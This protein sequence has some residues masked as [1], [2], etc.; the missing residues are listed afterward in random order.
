[1]ERLLRGLAIVAMLTGVSACKGH[2]AH[3]VGGVPTTPS[4]NQLYPY[5]AELCA[6]SQFRK[7]PDTGIEIEGGGFG[8]HAVMFLNGV[9]LQK[10]AH[11]PVLK[12]CDPG[13]DP[14][15][16][17]VGISVN[18]HY[19]NANWIATQGRSFFFHGLLRKGEGLTRATYDATVREAAR[20]GVLDGVT[21]RDVYLKARPPGLDE[22]TYKYQISLGT[23]YAL[24]YARDR[25]CAKVPLTRAGMSDA[26]TYLNR[27]NAPY[28][29]GQQIFKW[30]VVRNNCSHLYHNVLSAAG[31]WPVWP[32]NRPL[33]V[34]AFS[35]PTPKNEFVNLVRWTNEGAIDDVEA[36]WRDRDVRH[37]LAE[38]RG[39]ATAPGALIELER[40][41]QPN[42][43]Y[44]SNIQ[45]VFYDDPTIGPYQ[46]HYRAILAGARYSDLRANLMYFAA[47]YR[48]I[49]EARKPLA[50]HLRHLEYTDGDKPEDFRT[51]Y[52]QY[53][54]YIDRQRVMVQDTLSRIG[55]GGAAR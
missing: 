32:V 45:L 37:R 50:W 39:L 12:L 6:A 13:F 23:D 1:M 24:T 3:D 20:R 44:D 33:L 34:S 43:V 55:A 19:L 26:V 14:D 27:V 15:E 42:A 2:L 48:R 30:S 49:E 8:G 7:L 29:D 17:G 28:R 5:H 31:V 36:L 38:G 4:Y 18:D 35:F 10:D 54:N 53:Y 25:Y 40:I 52:A 16:D 46:R 9:C 21:F 51:F 22:A 47:L 41:A 11:Y